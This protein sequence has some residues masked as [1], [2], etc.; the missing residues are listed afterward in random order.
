MTENI[1]HCDSHECGCG[2]ELPSN[3][4]VESVESA[5][6]SYSTSVLN[7]ESSSFT[8]SSV[9]ADSEN[10]E[11][12][13]EAVPTEAGQRAAE[14][15]LATIR[16]RS[17]SGRHPELGKMINCQVCHVRH[18]ENE[19]K[20][21]QIF[22][23]DAEGNERSLART[24][25]TIK[26]VLGAAQF[27]G[28]RLRPPLNKRANEFVELVRSFLPDEYTQE[29]MRKARTRA[30]FILAEK[31]GRFGFLEPKWKKKNVEKVA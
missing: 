12:T 18:R 3:L 23:K 25:Q 7:D 19:R 8:D 29:D 5:L 10:Q 9:V 21:V 28:K 1:P 13:L 2:P 31:H 30:R 4:K 14:E 24:R 11:T 17:F 22:T 20:C 15:A 26:T 6:E 27:K 16:E